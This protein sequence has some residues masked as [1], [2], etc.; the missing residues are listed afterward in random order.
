[1]NNY[2]DAQKV[3]QGAIKSGVLSENQDSEYYAGN[4]M[5]MGDDQQ[6][7]ALFKNIITRTYMPPMFVEA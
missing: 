2:R 6:N 3:F 4:W 7:R 1:M 5:Y